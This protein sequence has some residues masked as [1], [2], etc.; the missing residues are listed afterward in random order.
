MRAPE[1]SDV[2]PDEL[3]LYDG[4]VERLMRNRP[5]GSMLVGYFGALLHSPPFAA[6]ISHW[7]SLVRS[8]G[9][10]D[11]SYSHVEREFVDMIL[12]FDSGYN[13]FLR[14]HLMDAIAVGVR[15]EAVEA[16]RSGDEDALT[17][18]ERQIVEYVRG[19]VGGTVSNEMWDAMVQRLGLRGAIEFTTFIS[20]LQASLRVHQAFGVPAV[21]DDELE[22][23]L[24]TLKDGTEP[25][26][27][28]RARFS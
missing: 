3:E 6:S 12:S 28:P 4:V 8:R 15:I 25:L 18:D 21:S 22:A 20:F 9:E 27:D 5:D 14:S 16:L 2:A 11:D 19:V 7:G 23:M 17:D 24:R 1:R 26:P 10:R 13:A